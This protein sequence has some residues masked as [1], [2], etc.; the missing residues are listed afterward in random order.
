VVW[1][2][3]EEG[4]SMCIKQEGLQAAACSGRGA[5]A[6]GLQQGARGKWG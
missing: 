4:V 2:G 6:G 3:R 5:G 1:G